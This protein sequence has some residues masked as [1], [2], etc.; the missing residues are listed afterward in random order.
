MTTLSTWLSINANT[1]LITGTAP[2]VTGNTL[3]NVIVSV[4]DGT[5]SVSQQFDVTILNVPVPIIDT[6][7]PVVTITFPLGITYNSNL[8]TLNYTAVDAE[9]NLNQCWYSINLGVTNSTPV[10]CSGTFS[11]TSTNGINRWTVYASDIAGNVG[12]NLVTFSV[13][14]NNNNGGSS[15]SN[16]KVTF[17]YEDPDTNRYETQTSGIQETIDLTNRTQEKSIFASLIG[18]IMNFFRWL[19]G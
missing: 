10:A 6:N 18:A 3:N 17:V 8:T 13:Q 1:G 9:G 19:F 4:A 2:I 12:S 5:N 16:K 7:A 11:I 14:S 15:S